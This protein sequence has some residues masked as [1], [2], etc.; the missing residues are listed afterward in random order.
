MILFWNSLLR[1]IKCSCAV[2]H[3]SFCCHIHALLLFLKHYTDANEKSL[4]LTCIEQLQKSKLWS[5]SIVPLKKIKPESGGMKMQQDK[6]NI[7]PA[8]PQVYIL[9]EMYQTLF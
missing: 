8:D 2:R 1:K 4:E 6:V 7:C 3:S 5:R 9:N